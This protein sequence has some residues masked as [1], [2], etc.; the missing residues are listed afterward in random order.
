V[1]SGCAAQSQGY[2]GFVNNQVGQV[3]GYEFGANAVDVS[4]PSNKQLQAAEYRSDIMADTVEN[5]ARAQHAELGV[6]DHKL[7]TARRA[8][9]YDHRAHMEKNTRTKDDFGTIRDV[10]GSISSTGSNINSAIYNFKNIFK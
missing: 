5:Q 2:G 7:D 6:V 9:V 1:C 4:G 10:T 3:R 8:Q